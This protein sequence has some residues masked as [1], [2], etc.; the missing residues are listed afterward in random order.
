MSVDI[1]TRQLPRL[2]RKKSRRIDQKYHNAGRGDTGAVERKLESLLELWCL[3][4]ASLGKQV[5]IFII[6]WRNIILAKHNLSADPWA[7]LCL[8]IRG[9]PPSPSQK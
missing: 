3:I 4:W 8:T 6:C 9:S 5:S 2:Y 7:D 1:R